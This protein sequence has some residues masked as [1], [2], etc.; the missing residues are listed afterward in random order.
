MDSIV[1][2]VQSIQILLLGSDMFF[3]V[4]I[5]YFSILSH[6]RSRGT[7]LIVLRSSCNY[8]GGSSPEEEQYECIYVF[9]VDVSVGCQVDISMLTMAKRHREESWS[10]FY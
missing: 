6:S 10:Y 3:E 4:I 9:L 7:I 2:E 5:T 8:C 1:I